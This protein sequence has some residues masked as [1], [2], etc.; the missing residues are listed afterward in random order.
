L[1]PVLAQLVVYR[2]DFSPDRRTISGYGKE[3]LDMI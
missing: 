3:L 2:W 1:I